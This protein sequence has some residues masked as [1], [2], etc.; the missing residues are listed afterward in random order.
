MHI[1]ITGASRGI[2]RAL[3]ELY[4]EP[5]V[6]LT[7]LARTEE[8][9]AGTVSRCE[10]GG[11]VVSVAGVDLCDA[12]AVV[13]WFNGAEEAA[14]VDL[15]VANAGV[16][17]G[18][19]ADG[20][21]ETPAEARRLVDINVTGTIATVQAAIPSMRRRKS[22]HIAIVSSLAALLPAADAPTY[23]ATKAALLAYGEALR[24]L[25]ADDGVAVSVIL[26]G[27]VRTDQTA[28][29]VGPLAFAINADQAAR[30]IKA[31]LARRRGMIAFPR[32]AH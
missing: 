32:R 17:D 12:E 5:G 7:L 2:G 31:G 29:H 11:A 3:A 13:A 20:C 27:H 1:A 6:R 18:H 14:P 23:G 10:A 16:F 25:L 21:L 9:L 8:G 30:R 15:L 26:P 28:R 4:A 22:G 19:G 24:L